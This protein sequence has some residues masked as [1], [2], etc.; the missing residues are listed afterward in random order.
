M[1]EPQPRLQASIGASFESSFSGFANS[2][3]PRGLAMN[4]QVKSGAMSAVF[5]GFAREDEDEDEV[6]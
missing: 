1:Q 4:S 2:L 3:P 6:P 5:E